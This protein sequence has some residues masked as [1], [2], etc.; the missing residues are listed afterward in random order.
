MNIEETTKPATIV[1]YSLREAPPMDLS[2]IK[3]TADSVQAEALKLRDVINKRAEMEVPKQEKPEKTS[4]LD[5]LSGKLPEQQTTQDLF[6]QRQEM[7]ESFLQSKGLTSETFGKI[8]T[9]GTEVASLNAQLQQLDIQEMQ[10]IEQATAG[11]QLS[12]I[13]GA[14]ESQIRRQMAIQKMGIAAQISAKTM[15]YDMLQGRVD[16]ATQEFNN[17]LTYATFKEKE[18]M[19]LSKWAMDFYYDADQDTKKWLQTD[20]ENS[21]N[22]YKQKYTEEQDKISNWFREQGLNIDRAQLGIQQ[23]EFEKELL[24]TGDR[25]LEILE[26]GRYRE[27][28]PEAG[29]DIGDTTL[30]AEDKVYMAYTLPREIISAKESG[31]SKEEIEMEV[32]IQNVVPP[33]SVETMP[34]PQD[35]QRVID[36][37]YKED[38]RWFRKN[39]KPFGIQ[40]FK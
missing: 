6:N 5:T 12:S 20:Y 29:I 13:K 3:A 40:I 4:F 17:Y 26:V 38:K 22:E 14:A 1:D 15:E 25:K 28:Y 27:Q 33:Y 37:V 23:Q 24:D 31:V 18:Q 21:Q 32:R 16:K 2:S 36:R 7:E 9:I 8:E 10:Q 39:F 11:L 19:D 35:I 34:I 30:S